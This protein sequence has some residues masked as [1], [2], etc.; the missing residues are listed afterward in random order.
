MSD[1]W[2]IAR[3]PLADAPGTRLTVERSARTAS[4]GEVLDGWR[5]D[6]AARSCL[7]RELR[8][9][10]HAAY[11][12]E[13]PPLTLDTLH[14]SFQCAV[15]PTPALERARP[16]ADAFSEHFCLDAHVVT[17]PNLGGDATLVAPC[18]HGPP[19][20][21]THLARFV[22]HAPEQQAHALVEE[23]AKQ[24][25]Q[26]ISERPLWLSTCGLGVFWLH[27]RLDDKPKYYSYRPYAR[28]A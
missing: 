21:Y 23:V 13:T 8:E 4:F 6:V 5:D 3:S 2:R 24:A 26:R 10:P 12:W 18:P 11:F 19:R 17:F 28:E 14:R 1:T 22:R 15:L 20:A 27:V 7:L 16:D 25:L 9:T